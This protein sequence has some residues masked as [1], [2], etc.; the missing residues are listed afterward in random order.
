M[1]STDG[2]SPFFPLQGTSKSLRAM[3]YLTMLWSAARLLA[4][5]APVTIYSWSLA[6]PLTILCA[7]LACCA[8]NL[9]RFSTP[10]NHCPLFAVF[11]TFGNLWH[12]LLSDSAVMYSTQR[13]LNIW[14]EITKG[15]W[16]KDWEIQILDLSL[17]FG[18]APII[19]GPESQGPQ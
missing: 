13:R 11:E 15:T 16:M 9:S 18:C 8:S 7:W 10:F 2:E 12:V 6:V 4:V 3:W 19:A 1:P 5:L 14:L 17:R